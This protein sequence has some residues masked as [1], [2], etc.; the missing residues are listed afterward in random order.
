MRRWARWVC[1][2]RSSSDRDKSGLCRQIDLNIY[3]QVLDLEANSAHF[4]V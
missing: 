3:P 4:T 2:L 1:W